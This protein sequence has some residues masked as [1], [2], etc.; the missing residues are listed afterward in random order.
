MR[1]PNNAHWKEKFN[2]LQERYDKYISDVQ[3]SLK[4]ILDWKKEMKSKLQKYESERV[5]RDGMRRELREVKTNER[6]LMQE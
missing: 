3:V 6:K 4:A 2:S 5:E 1:A